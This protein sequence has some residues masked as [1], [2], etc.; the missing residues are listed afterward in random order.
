[1]DIILLLS[2]RSVYVAWYDDEEEQIV[3]YQRIFLEDIVKMEIGLSCIDF[4]GILTNL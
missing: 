3:Q 4:G 1:M 2:Q